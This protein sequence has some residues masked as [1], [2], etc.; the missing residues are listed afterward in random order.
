MQ[1]SEPKQNKIKTRQKLFHGKDIQ[2]PIPIDWLSP[3][4]I[5]TYDHYDYYDFIKPKEILV[6]QLLHKKLFCGS[7]MYLNICYNSGCLEY[8]IPYGRLKGKKFTFDKWYSALYCENKGCQTCGDVYCNHCNAEIGASSITCSFGRQG[9]NE[10]D[11]NFGRYTQVIVVSSPIRILPKYH[12]RFG[13]FDNM[14]KL[15][16][17]FGN[18]QL[19]ENTTTENI[20]DAVSVVEVN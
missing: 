15:F 13:R 16:G 10:N 3:V 11:F 7:Y 9:K 12:M 14:E 4:L 8:T 2:F 18:E 20:V 17:S 1:I 19:A 6:N 5:A